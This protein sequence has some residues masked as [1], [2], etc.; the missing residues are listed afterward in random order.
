[1]QVMQLRSGSVQLHTSELWD[2]LPTKLLIFLATS[3]GTGGCH[4]GVH[5]LGTDGGGD[6][7][8]SWRGSNTFPPMSFLISKLAAECQA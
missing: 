5:P 6:V 8:S 3:G 1:M 2:A 7:A 4:V